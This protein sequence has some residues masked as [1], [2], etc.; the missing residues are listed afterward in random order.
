MLKFTL[1]NKNVKSGIFEEL[2]ENGRCNM[3]YRTRSRRSGRKF[4]IHWCEYCET[5]VK[6]AFERAANLIRS[7][8]RNRV[9][10]RFRPWTNGINQFKY[11]AILSDMT[12]IRIV[13]GCIV[14]V[15]LY[16][17]NYRLIRNPRGDWK[18][19]SRDEFNI[20]CSCCTSIRA[21]SSHCVNYKKSEYILAR[22]SS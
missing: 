18:N 4:I 20:M 9:R 2:I 1:V 16:T 13:R 22:Q 6:L 14:R 7:S 5:W 15:L 10:T 21:S 3:E 17:V 8:Y 11:L 12:R 19:L